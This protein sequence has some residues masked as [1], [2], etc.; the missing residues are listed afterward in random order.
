MVALAGSGA[1]ATLHALA[2]ARVGAPVVAVASRRDDHA[3]AL[4]ERVGARP[5][6]YDELPAG[7]DLVVVA[8]PPGV[9]LPH[10][11]AS[12]DRGARVLVESPLATTLADAD[13]L[14]GVAEA[15]GDVIYGENLAASAILR[16]AVQEVRA[17]SPVHDLEV[18]ALSP[19]PERRDLTDPV[20]GGGAMLD[21]GSRAVALAL[22]LA[23]DDEPVG[24]EAELVPSTGAAATPGLDES[25]RARLRFGSG[26]VARLEVSW[27]LPDAV[28][29]L[30]AAGPTGVVR[31]SL[32]PDQELERNGEPLRLPDVADHDRDPV[33]GLGFSSQLIETGDGD[34]GALDAHFGRAVLDVVCAAYAAARLGAPVS[35]PFD[36]RRDLTPAQ[37]WQG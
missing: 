9:H 17:I 32:L 37:L 21:L 33:V 10:V 18:R 35:L 2:A 22:L 5:C 30:Q 31:A 25:G 8:T 34:G 3:L 16:R 23:G 36:G 27:T 7:A 15:D 26:L 20:W 19:R 28:W 24:V 1:A 13:A 29:D 4:A 6:G 11:R 14:V 12:A